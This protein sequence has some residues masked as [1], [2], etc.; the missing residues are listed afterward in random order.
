MLHVD[1]WQNVI[2]TWHYHCSCKLVVLELHNSYYYIIVTILQEL[3]IIITTQ[4][5]SCEV[6][7]KSPHFFIVNYVLNKTP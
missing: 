3:Q 2:L 4:K 5:P 6:N 7:C 1:G